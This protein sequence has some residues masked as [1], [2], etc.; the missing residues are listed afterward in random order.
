MERLGRD[1]VHLLPAQIG[2]LGYLFTS[3]IDVC[4]AKLR[5]FGA[6]DSNVLTSTAVAQLVTMMVM[7]H[8]DHKNEEI[9]D[10]CYDGKV[11][12]EAVNRINPS[13][14]WTEV[15]KHFDQTKLAVR[16]RQVLRLLTDILVTGIGDPN[17]FPSNLL[18][19]VW[20]TNRA[21]QFTWLQWITQNPDIFFVL[22]YPHTPVNMNALKI[23][24]DEL[25]KDV[26]QW[27]C[28]NLI[29]VLLKLAETQFTSQVYSVFCRLTSSP[30]ALCPD[31]FLLGLI[32]APSPMRTTRLALIQECVTALLTNNQN[33]IGVLNAAW[34]CDTFGSRVFRQPILHALLV[35][36]SKSPDDQSRLTKILEI[37]H[38]LK[39]NGLA[40]LFSIQNQSA[41]TIDLACLASKRDYLKLDKWID[42]KF[43]ELGDSFS[44]HVV[45]HIKR[46]LPA[47]LLGGAGSQLFAGQ[48][49]LITLM[50]ILK[51]KNLHQPDLLREL[52]SF[53]QQMR[54]AQAKNGSTPRPGTL[55]P[56]I[57]LG[58]NLPST[59]GTP[60]GPPPAGS[61]QSM[62]MS[63]QQMLVGAVGEPAERR[64]S[65]G[66]RCSEATAP[67]PTEPS[68][69]PPASALRRTRTPSASATPL[70]VS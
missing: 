61:P 17:A 26:M 50:S 42:D 28:L 37:G 43:M 23:Q 10:L 58:L 34:N 9:A 49:T 51:Q 4:I 38:E 31:L 6:T 14:S 30:L 39:P 24:P 16:S 19:Q 57:P 3:S 60:T 53:A 62:Q 70:P 29:D 46:R 54:I 11:F 59:P 15:I 25:S 56:N 7:Q 2:E 40:E 36:Y 1:N 41:F 5:A 48:D 67:R 45:Q 55:P 8:A 13:L 33:A 35:Y 69:A 64:C 22:D 47:T 12:A 65:S 66:T 20:P 44:Y 68:N 32:Q 27:K 63:H 18:Y 52:Q 21:G